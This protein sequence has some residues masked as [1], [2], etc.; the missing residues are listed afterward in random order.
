MITSNL[1]P[2]VQCAR[3]AKKA[4]L[5]LGQLARGVSYRDKSTF[6]KLYKTFVLPHLSYAASAW[7]PYS[8][9][10][11]ELL[12]KVQK[13]AVMMVTNVRGNYEERLAILRLRTLEDR[14][15]RGDMIETY[16]ILTGKSKVS[17]ETWFC[18]AKE[19][20]GVVNTRATK[21]YLNLVVPPVPQSDIRRNFF[22]HRVVPVW[23]SLPE[24][25]KR[26]ST[27]DHFKASYDSLTGY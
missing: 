15:I 3:A 19:K 14:R 20:D 17:L 5:V 16:K 22:S 21:G 23:N 6:I 7:C 18:L 26:S 10:D 27:T 12:E 24:S 13:R 1:K 4:N 11:K 2:S 25:V 8:K 9:G